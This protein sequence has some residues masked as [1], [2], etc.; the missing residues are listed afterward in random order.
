MYVLNRLIKHDGCKSTTYPSACHYA[1]VGQ[2][3]LFDLSLETTSSPEAGWC[4]SQVALMHVRE[5]V[6]DDVPDFWFEH[7]PSPTAA[8]VSLLVVAALL[9]L[10][11]ELA[12]SDSRR[13]S[14]K[15]RST[16]VSLASIRLN[17]LEKGNR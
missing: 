2:S 4:P 14:S 15:S 16:S 17:R 11:V 8:C 7:T 9:L 6:V 13:A 5:A 10:G 1:E 3:S 12:S